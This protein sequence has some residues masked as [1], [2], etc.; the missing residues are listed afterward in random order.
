MTVRAVFYLGPLSHATDFP[1]EK[2]YSL[3]IIP[4][5]WVFGFIQKK[6]KLFESS[7]FQLSLLYFN[8]M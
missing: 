5:L 4:N 3:A 1:H 8:D 6:E 7:S 2:K